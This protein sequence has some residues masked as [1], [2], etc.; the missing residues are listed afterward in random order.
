MLCDG[1]TLSTGMEGF[2]LSAENA[3]SDMLPWQ[4]HKVTLIINPCF[5]LLT[6]YLSQE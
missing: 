6:V 5:P 2:F 3:A 4:K 1:W